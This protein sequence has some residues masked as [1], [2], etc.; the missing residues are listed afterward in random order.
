MTGKDAGKQGLI[1]GVIKQRNWVFVEGLNTKLRGFNMSKNVSMVS[2][3]KK[4][5][6]LVVNRDVKLIDPTDL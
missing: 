3:M 5:M 1:N 2:Y 4:E 6:P